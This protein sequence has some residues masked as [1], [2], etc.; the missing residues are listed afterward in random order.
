[1]TTA[2]SKAICATESVFVKRFN[3]QSIIVENCCKVTNN[4]A[5]LAIFNQLFWHKTN[6]F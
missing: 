6:S 1:M 3:I 5:H 4:I 2:Y